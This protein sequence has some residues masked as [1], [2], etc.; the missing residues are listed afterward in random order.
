MNNKEITHADIRAAIDAVTGA[1]S[2]GVVAEVTPGLVADIDALINGAPAAPEQRVI[3][4]TE[5][6]KT[7]AAG[8]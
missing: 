1:P 7:D 5:T 3:K 8:Q 6:R 4:A 2:S